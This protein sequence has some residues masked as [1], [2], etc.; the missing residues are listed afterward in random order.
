MSSVAFHSPDHETVRVGGAE[1]AYA[2]RLCDRILH[3]VLDY[4]SFPS[5]EDSTLSRLKRMIKPDHYLAKYVTSR[6]DAGLIQGL[7]NAIGGYGECLYWNG[8]PVRGFSLALNTAI[9]LGSDPLRFSAR[10]HGS[11][12]IHGFVQGEHRAWLASIIDAG[13]ASGVLRAAPQTQYGNWPAVVAMLQT[14]TATPVVMSYSVTES[15]PNFAVTSGHDFEEKPWSKMSESEQEAMRERASAFDEL[16]DDDRWRQAFSAL[17]RISDG[18]CDLEMRPSD[19]NTFR[20]THEL[21]ALDLL[22]PDWTERLDRKFPCSE[23][24]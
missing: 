5:M 8:Q 9:V 23:A 10:M 2:G 21:S 12:E 7:S 19:W 6:D 24:A 1:R 17:T 11:C 4:A 3:G 22:A 13:M 18:G 15:F 16:D 14:S 20:F